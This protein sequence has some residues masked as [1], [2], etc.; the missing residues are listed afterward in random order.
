[1][2][3]TTPNY[4]GINIDADEGPLLKTASIAFISLT[5]YTIAIRCFSRWYTKIPLGLDDLFILIAAVLLTLKNHPSHL[6][7]KPD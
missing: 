1:M 2:S 5:V 3:F 6:N 7:K 4:L